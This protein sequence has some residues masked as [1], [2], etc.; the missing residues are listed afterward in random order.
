MTVK[1]ITELYLK[2]N[3]YDGLYSEQ[4][5]CGCT[6]DDLFP[7]YD[8]N[9]ERCCAGYRLKGGIEFRIGPKPESE[10]GNG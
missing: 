1:E 6:V 2:S 5:E 7:C 10:A 3:G 9:P 4:Y 8:S